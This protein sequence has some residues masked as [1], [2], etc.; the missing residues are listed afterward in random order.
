MTREIEV[1]SSTGKKFLKKHEPGEVK[2]KIAKEL[3]AEKKAKGRAP[4]FV[5]AAKRHHKSAATVEGCFEKYMIYGE[6]WFQPKENTVERFGKKSSIVTRVINLEARL[7]ALEG[8]LG[9]AKQ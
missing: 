4:D 5:A 9:V 7:A 6:E 2:L 3:A 1:V 8:Q